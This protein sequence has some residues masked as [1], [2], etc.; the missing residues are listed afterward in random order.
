MMAP[1]GK[2]GAVAAM[3]RGQ[4]VQSDPA[5]RKRRTRRRPCNMSSI[6][7]ESQQAEHRGSRRMLPR[8][9]LLRFKREAGCIIRTCD[10]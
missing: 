1:L 4:A 10:G 5:A 2:E 7:V 8:E 3:A 9:L 6:I